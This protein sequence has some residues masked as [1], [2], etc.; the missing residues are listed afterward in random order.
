MRQAILITAYKNIPHLRRIVDYFDDDF[1]VFIHIDKKCREDYVFLRK[2]SHVHLFD[3]YRIAWGD[4]NH[5]KAILLLMHEAYRHDDLE[6]FHLITGSDYPALPLADFKSFCEHHKHD[7]FVEHFP[8]PH[9]D[10]GEEGGIDRIRYYWV[11][12]S[13]RVK[14]GR[15][16]YKFIK[17]IDAG[18]FMA[19]Y[20]DYLFTGHDLLNVPVCLTD[21]PLLMRNFSRPILTGG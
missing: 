10:W 20:L 12:P 4:V 5:L 8:L 9:P 16:V 14:H 18:L 21:I 15:F 1:E 7:N 13:Y 3:R 6:Y 19:E 17:L 2:I 11:Q